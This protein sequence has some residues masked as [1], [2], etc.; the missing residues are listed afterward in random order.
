[1]V[2]LQNTLIC[3]KKIQRL[4][5]FLNQVE[6]AKNKFAGK[7]IHFEESDLVI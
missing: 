5:N 1:M 6:Y 4:S 7:I 3:T 2:V